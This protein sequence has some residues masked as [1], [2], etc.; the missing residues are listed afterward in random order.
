MKLIVVSRTHKESGNH[1]ARE[2]GVRL[3]PVSNVDGD[4]D[5]GNEFDIGV[6]KE[7]WDKL[8]PGMYFEVKDEPKQ[9]EEVL[10]PGEPV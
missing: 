10:V 1:K 4:F 5:Y 2:Y 3:E 8:V 9:K 6:P 7:L